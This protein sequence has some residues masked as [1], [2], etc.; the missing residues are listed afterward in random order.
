M[1]FRQAATSVRAGI[2][3][4]AYQ[5]KTD[6]FSAFAQGFAPIFAQGMKDKKDL[7]MAE[8]KTIAEE[9]RYQRRLTDAAQAKTD[10][11]DKKTQEVA[12]RLW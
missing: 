9:K 11:Y 5:K 8:M 3:S 6:N 2:K 12:E 7:K 4:G 10:L 1:S